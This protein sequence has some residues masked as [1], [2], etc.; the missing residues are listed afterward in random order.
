MAIRA[1]P[2]QGPVLLVAPAARG[3]QCPW[4]L[5]PGLFRVR[6][7]GREGV[8]HRL[9]PGDER[10]EVGIEVGRRRPGFTAKESVPM[11]VDRV[12]EIALVTLHGAPPELQVY[13][14]V[15]RA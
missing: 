4:Q 2:G 3:R 7:E 15:R 13:S 6:E 12:S 10:R 8:S 5:L 9:Q 14:S 11:V 1:G